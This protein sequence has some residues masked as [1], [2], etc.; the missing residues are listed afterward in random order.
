MGLYDYRHVIANER[1]CFW[2]IH[3]LRW[4]RGVR[5]PACDSATVWAMR[6]QGAV[7][8]RCKACRR[9]FSLRSNGVHV[10]DLTGTPLLCDRVECLAGP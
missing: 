1:T 7:G 2:F 3:R 8:Y 6:E 9:H 10:A 5:C 4:P